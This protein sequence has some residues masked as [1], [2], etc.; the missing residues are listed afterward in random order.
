MRIQNKNDEMHV[1]KFFNGGYALT[2]LDIAHWE[3]NIVPISRLQAFIN[4]I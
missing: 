1:F 3:Q 2:E 4:N